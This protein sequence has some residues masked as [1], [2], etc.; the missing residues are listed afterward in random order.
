MSEPPVPE[1]APKRPRP[2]GGEP[3][4][5][6]D[7]FDRSGTRDVIGFDAAKFFRG[8]PADTV[9]RT[10]GASFRVHRALIVPHLPALA[11][12]F[13]EGLPDVDG[14]VWLDDDGATFRH[15]LAVLYSFRCGKTGPLFNQVTGTP[16]FEVRRRIEV[17]PDGVRDLFLKYNA[18]ELYGIIAKCAIVPLFQFRVPDYG[19][20]KVYVEEEDLRADEM[21][22]LVRFVHVTAHKERWRDTVRLLTRDRWSEWW[23]RDR[24]WEEYP[25]EAFL[26]KS[27]FTEY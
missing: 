7:I 27:L 3:E 10:R 25:M 22:W 23:K 11:S 13:E 15:F 21:A 24:V 9:L 20:E 14:G 12:M 2:G 1:P 16:D 18:G 4:T 5:V 26:A 6:D 19:P 17:F 8:C